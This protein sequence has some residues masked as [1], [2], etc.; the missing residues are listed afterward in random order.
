ML[1]REKSCKFYDG[2]GRCLHSVPGH[3]HNFNNGAVCGT[4]FCVGSQIRMIIWIFLTS[5]C[6]S[7]LE[8]SLMSSFKDLTENALTTEQEI[9]RRE[10]KVTLEGQPGVFMEK[11]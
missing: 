11:E 4:I 8:H 5:Y 7:D 10:E 3:V 6:S 1:F 9:Q 2:K